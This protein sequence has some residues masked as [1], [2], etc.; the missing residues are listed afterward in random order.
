VLRKPNI[1]ARGTARILVGLVVVFGVGRVLTTVM[2]HGSLAAM[3]RER[4]AA[5]TIVSSIRAEPRSFNRY[6]ARDLTTIVI[7]YLSQSPLVRVNR[8]TN[9]LEP[10]LAE[11]WDLLPD[12]RTYR[13]RLRPGLRFSDGAPFSADDVVFS[14]NAI[15]DERTASVLADNLRVHGQPIAVWAEDA[16]TVGI[17]FP[18][19]FGPGLR[20]IES[21]PILPRHL[22]QRRLDAG[23]LRSAWGPSTPPTELTGL[24]PFMLRRYDAGQRLTFDRNPYHWRWSSRTSMRT[25]SHVVLDVLPDQEA[26]SL[27]LETGTIDFTQSEIRPSDFGGLKRAIDRGRLAVTDLGVGL[28]GDLFWINLRTAGAKDPR[29]QW[30][31]HPDFRRIISHSIDREAFVDSVYMGAAVPAYGLISPGN[32]EWYVDA[33]SPPYD[34]AAAER[35]LASLNLKPADDGMLH[36]AGGAPIHFT[37]LTQKGNSSLERGAAV[38]RESLAHLGVRVDV[39]ALEVGT[40]IEYVSSGNYDAAYFRLL[41][42]DTDPALNSEFWLSSGSAHIWNPSQHTPATSW[43]SEI[44]RLMDGVSTT[45]E[46]ARRRALFAEVQRTMA[47][48]L[49]VLCFAFPRLSVAINTRIVDATPAPFRPPV[50]WN[51][52]AIGVKEEFDSRR[53]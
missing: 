51:P 37:L 1:G 3:R 44:D 42:T 50:L 41:L 4:H 32:R 7:T 53:D 38:I 5:D 20:L 45:M 26:E 48:E 27:G 10:E 19:A 8:I 29:H 9:Q 23:T 49:P 14:F 52:S 16:T 13:V 34:I 25:L 35:L 21:V 40:L 15:Y 31:Q 47:R 24:G 22:L 30:L 43:E 36:D 6:A 2:S 28:D 12:N 46:P 11:T 33:P 39:V 17:R 18:S